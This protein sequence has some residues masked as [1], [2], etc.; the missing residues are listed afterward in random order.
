M[1]ESP[2]TPSQ[3][4][5]QAARR[6]ERSRHALQSPEGRRT[7]V[8]G[9]VQFTAPLTPSQMAAR[10]GA[11]APPPPQF[12]HVAPVSVSLKVFSL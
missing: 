11:P 7:P 8:P 5:Q 9:V 10:Y 2:P 6:L 3:H 12:N 4:R 1:P